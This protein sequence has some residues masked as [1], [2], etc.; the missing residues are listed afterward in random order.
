MGTRLISIITK[1]VLLRVREWTLRIQSKTV[2][3][4]TDQISIFFRTFPNQIM[5]SALSPP[6]HT[7]ATNHAYGKEVALFDHD[8]ITQPIVL[9]VTNLDNGINFDE[10]ER[11][12]RALKK[13][14]KEVSFFLFK[15]SSTQNQNQIFITR[16]NFFRLNQFF[17]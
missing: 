11:I 7:K 5:E 17:C 3:L 10:L 6:I 12:L 13:Q 8:Y 14:C 16:S 4:T 1:F 2:L 15:N 9:H